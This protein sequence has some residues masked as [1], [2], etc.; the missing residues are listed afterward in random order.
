MILEALIDGKWHGIDGLAEMLKLARSEMKAILEFLEK[1]EL[2]EIDGRDEKVKVN[3][4]LRRLPEGR[5]I[6]MT[7]SLNGP[8]L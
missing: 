6:H 7:R 3:D 2:A 4:D 8:P 5:C 1:F